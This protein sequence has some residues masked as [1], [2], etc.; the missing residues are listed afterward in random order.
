LLHGFGTQGRVGLDP[1]GPRVVIGTELSSEMGVEVG[2]EPLWVQRYLMN[3]VH[4]L[5]VQRLGLLKRRHHPPELETAEV[6]LLLVDFEVV[7]LR[8]GH[9]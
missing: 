2:V 8:L 4:S 9:S 1:M 6:E 3:V 7:P 5:V